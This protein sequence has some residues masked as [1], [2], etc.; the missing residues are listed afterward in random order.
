MIPLSDIISIK[1]KYY[2]ALDNSIEVKTEKVS[3]FFTNY[4]SRDNCFN[5]LKEE[6]DKINQ[7]KINKSTSPNKIVEKKKFE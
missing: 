1:K 4:L 5:L 3:Y 6:L 2:L 7:N